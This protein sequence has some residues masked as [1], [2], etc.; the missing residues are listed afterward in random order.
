MKHSK[1]SLNFT[2]SSTS[3][4]HDQPAHRAAFARHAKAA[5]SEPFA[6]NN[7]FVPASARNNRVVTIA[8]AAATAALVG[9]IV[10]GGVASVPQASWANGVV[11]ADGSF[12]YANRDSSTKA[13][14]YVDVS[15]IPCD[16]N[17]VTDKSKADRKTF[18][19]YYSVT[20]TFNSNNEY[21]GG[22]PFW[23]CT[24][25]QGAEV[26]G[27]IKRAIY[28]KDANKAEKER[29]FT[30]A[31]SGSDNGFYRHVTNND[32]GNDSKFI[33]EWMRQTGE[34]FGYSNSGNTFSTSQSYRAKSKHLFIDWTGAGNKKRVVSFMLKVTDMTKPLYFT[35]GV[36]Q[37]MGNW[38]Y[39]QGKVDMPA[40]LPPYAK[41]F[42]LAYPKDRLEVPEG[43]LSDDLRG[44][45]LD[46][47]W[48]AN[49]TNTDLLSK[50]WDMPD[51][52]AADDAT[53]AAFKKAV[54]INKDGSATVTYKDN[55]ADFTSKDEIAKEALTKKYIPLNK[56]I[57]LKYPKL[58]YVKDVNKL[59][60]DEQNSVKTAFEEANKELKN[61][62]L[63][64]NVAI[65]EKGQVTVT[66]NDTFKPLSQTV[67]DGTNLVMRKRSLAEQFV[68]YYPVEMGVK[69]PN[70]LDESQRKALQKRIYDANAANVGFYDAIGSI[71]NIRVA[72]NGDTTITY[73]DHEENTYPSQDKMLG[74]R[75][76]YKLPLL[77]EDTKIVVKRPQRQVVKNKSHL[78]EQEKTAIR[79]ALWNANTTIQK[80][81]KAKQDAF[82]FDDA[83][84]VVKVTFNDD[85]TR[86]IP[87]VELMYVLGQAETPQKQLKMQNDP[88]LTYWITKILVDNKDTPTQENWRDFV[89]QFLKDNF[90]KKNGDELTDADLPVSDLAGIFNDGGMVISSKKDVWAPKEQTVNMNVA[91]GSF[92]SQNGPVSI[93]QHDKI[94]EIKGV[95]NGGYSNS[96]LL[97]QLTNEDCFITKAPAFDKKTK[98]KELDDLLDKIL[99]NNGIT[100]DEDKKKIK[101]KIKEQHKNDINNMQS[102]SD[103]NGIVDK[104]KDNA[105]VEATK[106]KKIDEAAKKLGIG[107]DEEGKKKKEELE[108]E[109]ENVTDPDEIDKK[110]TEKQ[111]KEEQQKQATE[112]EEHQKDDANKQKES[113]NKQKQQEQK[114]ES[115]KAQQAQQEEADKKKGEEEQKKAELEKAKEA[116]KKEIDNNPNLTPEDKNTY[117]KQVEDAQTT[118]DVNTAK[119][120]ATEKGN[121][122]KT[123]ADN[124]AKD[125]LNDDKN[126]AK[127]E[128]GKM[129]NLDGNAKA[130]FNGQIQNANS[131]DE[132]AEILENA[133]KADAQAGGKKKIEALKNN[134]EITP[135]EAEAYNKRIDAATSSRE[136]DAIVEEAELQSAKKKAKDAIDK[137]EH[138]N[139]A[140]KKALTDEIDNAVT[141][142]TQ[143]DSQNTPTM[144]TIDK[145]KNAITQTVE[146]A[147]TLDQKMEELGK[148]AGVATAQKSELEKKPEYKDE[149]KTNFETA[150]TAAKS[151]VDKQQGENADAT[152]IQ[153]AI[154]KLKQALEALGG[155]SVDK[156]ALTAEIATSEK[157]KGKPAEGFTPEVP[158]N[159]AYA[160]ATEEKQKEFDEALKA[161]KTVVANNAA[162]EDAVKQATENLKAAREALN[163]N[164]DSA[165]REALAAAN[166]KVATP[167]YI[168]AD[169]DKKDDLTKAMAEG[170]KIL[171]KKGATAEEIANATRLLNDAA[172][173]LNGAI[174]GPKD[175]IQVWDAASL[176]D[177]EV[178]AVQDGIIAANPNSKLAANNVVVEK[179]T[180]AAAHKNAGTTTVKWGAKQADKVELSATDTIVEHTST[181]TTIK[182]PQEKLVVS[183]SELTAEQ[184]AKLKDAI[185][186]A[187]A[188]IS[189]SVAN[190]A[191]DKNGNATITYKDGT[192]TE[193]KADSLISV[194][195]S[196]DD[197]YA[198]HAM[199]RLYNPYTHEHLFTTDAAEKDN[200]VSLGWNFEG[201]TG[202]V[203]MHGEKGGVYRLYNPNTG[204]HHYTTKEDE[205]AKCVKAGWKNEGVKFFSVLDADKQTVGMVSMYNPYEKKFYHHC[206]SDAD[207]IAK[208]VKDGWR[209]EEIKW[210]AAK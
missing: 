96:D 107:D 59:T 47:L 126:A 62:N 157:L 128:I 12:R 94:L 48:E 202:K 149:K 49:K 133:R 154:T 50:L 171:K 17:G 79:E 112:N 14:K 175:K 44:R 104:V 15:A 37:V 51:K 183:S 186:K 115:D 110:V 188:D 190:V 25:P 117:R 24:I 199:Y 28:A 113:E 174:K 85:S 31:E 156:S 200:L 64:N 65:N 160:N 137:L 130:R 35:A 210:Y 129:Q 169:K 164:D 116:A 57:A 102:E 46:N 89:K 97:I 120:A 143:V 99:E 75:L 146:K 54:V 1:S 70:Q 127:E 55:A 60:G 92:T 56:R 3:T 159:F 41:E 18:G 78:E 178:K 173:A 10:W 16:K 22:R 103:F 98:E 91:D 167:A 13:Q 38:H 176:T 8:K 40:M 76:L 87:Y 34:N 77:S 108:K 166:K 109:L 7:L 123:A 189:L 20:Y 81:L 191:V 114:I 193:L 27:N 208:M 9:V 118:D 209:K 196:D 125:K 132:V 206:T 172:Q 141:D 119:T 71:D 161:A 66:F 145:V 68:P 23:W 177:A 43:D 142:P 121:T 101:D 80:Y 203:Y 165:L 201:I 88:Y 197:F 5:G 180:D 26:V 131:A 90:K 6:L 198:L 153:D 52:I 63:I 95:K 106:K 45:L 74:S 30:L 19:T 42:E 135:D 53:K 84:Q 181:N 192:K 11:T 58:T 184:Q 134:N 82:T 86:Q 29:E 170:N 139:N 148:L 83:N 67:V 168:E 138:L 140:Q 72:E 155:S 151:L 2:A 4:M 152:K 73:K 39:T 204:E 61:K 122:N 124:A 207:E 194:S 162:T 144:D 33:D 36:Y 69:N 158:A 21:W 136:I 185:V 32:A 93:C 179:K 163:G 150:L 100:N 111:N 105:N 187:N 147:K 195:R 205:L 182:A